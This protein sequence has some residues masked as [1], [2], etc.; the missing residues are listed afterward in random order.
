MWKKYENILVKSFVDTES[1]NLN[2]FIPK[3]STLN[4]AESLRKVKLILDTKS[5]KEF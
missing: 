5:F 2:G 3:A 4:E 1:F